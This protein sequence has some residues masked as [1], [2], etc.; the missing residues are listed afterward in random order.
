MVDNSFLIDVV[1]L[2]INIV[3]FFVLM[4]VL[5]GNYFEVKKNRTKTDKRF[6][7]YGLAL[8]VGVLSDGLSFV[9]EI[10]VWPDWLQYFV[11]LVSFVAGG[12]ISFMFILYLLSLI[13]ERTKVKD[14][15][16]IWS[17]FICGV[18]VIVDFVLSVTGQYFTITNGEYVDGPR[19][20][21]S[22]CMSVIFYVWMCVLI[23]RFIKVL[24]IHDSVAFISYILVPLVGSVIYMK[25]EISIE[26]AMMAISM[27]LI[28][29]MIQ[30]E[31]QNKARQREHVL[32]NQSLTDEMTGLFNRAAHNR[33]IYSENGIPA[34]F[35]YMSL[36]LNGLKVTNDSMGH[37]AGD[38]LIIAAADCIK[39][40]FDSIGKCY[41]IGGDEFS[42][43][44]DCS[45]EELSHAID[46][47]NW[48]VEQWS[49]EHNQ[50][51]SISYGFASFREF[52]HA[53]NFGIDELMK[54][55]DSRMYKCKAEYYESKDAPAR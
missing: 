36:D 7:S 17:G 31:D 46:I 32:L 21:I 47:F 43:L 45:S 3:C 20:A 34:D 48:N 19:T 5:Y 37:A 2:A 16:Y 42:C 51:L 27:L 53:K 4:I 13:G 22:A 55:A 11:T 8:G 49:K 1:S 25:F 35:I 26:Y 6:L 41:R 39:K 29:V 30:A 10:F 52:S 33:D 18:T 15:H 28:F 9:G 50:I 40:S 24:G 23:I 54:V 12:V 14:E 38:K 44:L